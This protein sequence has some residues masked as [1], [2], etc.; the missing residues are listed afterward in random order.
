MALPAGDLYRDLMFDSLQEAVMPGPLNKGFVKGLH[1][2]CAQ[3]GIT[4]ADLGLPPVSLAMIMDL[5]QLQ[6]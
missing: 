3:S 6:Q 1:E 5:S 2:Q 4:L